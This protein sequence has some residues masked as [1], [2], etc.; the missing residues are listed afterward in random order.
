VKKHV[1][2]EIEKVLRA[3]EGKWGREYLVSW[4]G[5]SSKDNS[6]IGDLPSFFKK[7]SGLY[8]FG[9]KR[10]EMIIESDG[11][12]DG[13]SEDECGSESDSDEEIVVDSDDEEVDSSSDEEDFDESDDVHERGSSSK[14]CIAT[15]SN[16]TRAKKDSA[17]EKVVHR[18][19]KKFL[20]EDESDNEEVKETP[21]VVLSIKPKNPRMK[22][23]KKEQLAMRA[24]CALAD[25]VN[26]TESDSD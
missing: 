5:Y 3:R 26:D 7:N 24:L 11:D 4:K 12:S 23:S 19:I 1:L 13:G 15:R 8:D 25:Y 22:G 20:E 17:S 2:Y 16:P 9:K 18:N 21:K 6:W 14:K 10:G